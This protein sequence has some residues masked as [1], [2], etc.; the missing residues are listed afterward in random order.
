MKHIILLLLLSLSSLS[1]YA[2]DYPTSTGSVFIEYRELS[3][4]EKLYSAIVLGKDY[5]YENS[6]TDEYGNVIETI[7]TDKDSLYEVLTDL[8]NK[9]NNTLPV[10][11]IPIFFIVFLL[12]VYVLHKHRH[13]SASS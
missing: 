1:V 8:Y 6:V 4:I 5:Y 11:D 12:F 7:Y 13:N 2:V 9:Y 10:S 3:L